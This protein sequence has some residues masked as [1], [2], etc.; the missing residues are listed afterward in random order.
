MKIEKLPSGTY[1]VRK[2]VDKKTY[3]FLFEE[4][5]TKR[6]IDQAL[7]EVFTKKQGKTV[8]VM[9]FRSA[10]VAYIDSKEYVL[11]PAT[12][13][14]YNRK[15][16]SVPDWFKSLNLES[17]NHVHVQNFVNEFSADK[18]YSTVIGVYNFVTAVLAF[19]GI[20]FEQTIK[21]PMKIKR[22]PYCPTDD[23]VRRLMEASKHTKFE[24]AIGLAVCGLRR[25][26]IV[27]VT[28]SD[29]HNNVV[30]V[31]KA[32]VRDKNKQWVVK[33]TK[34]TASTREVPVPKKLADK[35]ILQG[36]AYDGYPNS[37][38]TWINKQTR[39]LGIPTFSVHAL[40][41]YFASK[42]FYMGYSKREIEILGGWEK[43]SQALEMIYTQS[44]LANSAAGRKQ[45]MD[46]FSKD[47]F[48]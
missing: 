38:T 13:N 9:T 10:A 31:N 44:M 15:L 28:A 23:D 20:R 27:C 21:L 42:L 47:L 37:I 14:E 39:K 36:K 25:S 7:A 40:R 19:Y 29:V 18:A 35:I 41:H 24:C 5:P 12:V 11:S 16:K 2:T 26:E 33:S 6:E 1:R 48:S 43:G 34:T 17:I 22:E 8:P 32:L 4:K 45:I 30:L 46:N 3:S